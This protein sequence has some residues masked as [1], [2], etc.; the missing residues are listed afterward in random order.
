MDLQEEI[1]ALLTAKFQ[2]VRKD[3]LQQLAAG[4]GLQAANKEEATALVD[5]LTAEQV[6]KFIK[7]WRRS[8]DAEIK[9]ANETHE[10]GLRKKY[11]FKE[12]EAATTTTTTT[13][14]DDKP[15]TLAAIRELIREET[16][17]VRDSITTLNADKV[18]TTRR[19]QFVK[20]LDDAKVQGR[21]RDMMLRNFDRVNTFADDDAFNAYMT[22]AQGDITALAQERADTGLQGHDK[23]IFG[24]V[25]D[26]GVSS[27]VADYI[28]AQT[29]T[30]PALTGKAL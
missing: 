23:P 5:K 26:K 13:E 14:D 11:D 7:D 21:Q 9:K 19:E 30:A 8:T 29:E 24:A 10:A 16:K 18:A 2:G 1:L 27:G 12:K 28:K 17:G 15:I 25:N 20:A 3:G 4:L 22:E 6:D